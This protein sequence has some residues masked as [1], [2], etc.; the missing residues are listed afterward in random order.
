MCPVPPVA[1]RIS[2]IIPVQKTGHP[3]HTIGLELRVAFNAMGSGN[4]DA[5]DNGFWLRKCR[6]LLLRPA[7]EPLIL[8]RWEK[9]KSFEMTEPELADFCSLLCASKQGARTKD[10][11]GLWEGSDVRFEP[12]DKAMTWWNDIRVVV[13]DPDL[14]P[15]LPAYGFARTIIAHPYPDGNGRLAR[16]LVHAAL[17]R[18]AHYSAPFLPLAPAFYM[19]GAKVAAALRRL[20]YTGDWQG[21]N[22]VFQ[23]VLNC[24][25]NLS[26]CYRDERSS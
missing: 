1:I 25:A 21:F 7:V 15:L 18:T 13:D 19:N 5:G 9:L 17:A 10:S 24:A 16:A 11:Y 4:S 23:S 26:R 14:S 2:D 12:A 6:E 22:D 3:L 20:S 8:A